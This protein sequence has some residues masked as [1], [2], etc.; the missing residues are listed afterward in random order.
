MIHL[1]QQRLYLSFWKPQQSLCQLKKTKICNNTKKRSKKVNKRKTF[2]VETGIQ[3]YSFFKR[4]KKKNGV[5]VICSD[6]PSRATKVCFFFIFLFFFSVCMWSHDTFFCCV[7][8]KKKFFGI[9]KKKTDC[10][11]LLD[12]LQKTIQ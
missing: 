7:L 8:A 4:A 10:C 3:N 2:E 12:A 6:L 5:S 11:K 1:N 9:E